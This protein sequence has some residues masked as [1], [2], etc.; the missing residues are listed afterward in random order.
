MHISVNSAQ[1]LLINTEKLWEGEGRRGGEQKLWPHYLKWCTTSACC[2]SPLGIFLHPR[3]HLACL[4]IRHLPRRNCF[5][6]FLSRSGVVLAC[7]PWVSDSTSTHQSSHTS[8]YFFEVNCPVLLILLS[9]LLWQRVCKR[10]P[11]G[12]N[13]IKE[14]APLSRGTVD[15]Q[16]RGWKRSGQQHLATTPASERNWLLN[17]LHLYFPRRPLDGFPSGEV[18]SWYVGE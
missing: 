2:F 13:W 14:V 5:L 15:A 1:T 6:L 16:G 8:H 3:L 11:R 18:V 17:Y 9:I 12:N 10:T 4:D 7:S